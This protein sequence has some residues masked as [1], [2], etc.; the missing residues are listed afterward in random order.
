VQAGN[1]IVIFFVR[2]DK[3]GGDS[4]ADASKRFF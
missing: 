2:L 1:I 3:D 4:L